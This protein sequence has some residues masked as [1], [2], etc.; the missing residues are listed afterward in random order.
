MTITAFDECTEGWF[1]AVYRLGLDDGRSVVLKVAPPPAVRVLRY[2][3]DIIR[4]EV[5]AMRLVGERTAVP[6]PAVSRGTTR[7]TSCRAPTS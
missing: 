3:A 4:T 1:N 5:D 2:E 6:V 7:A